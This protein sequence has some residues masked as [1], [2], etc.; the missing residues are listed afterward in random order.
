L[1]GW[2]RRSN[3]PTLRGQQRV[4]DGNGR[5]GVGMQKH[6]LERVLFIVGNRHCGKSTQLRSMF[7][8]VRLGTAGRIPIE[9]KLDDFHRLTNDRFLYLRLSSP[10][11]LNESPRG[12][13]AKTEDKI[14]AAH[15]ELGTRWNFASALQANASKKMP[16]AVET[17]STFVEHFHPERTRVAV[18]NP[19]R[20]G[21]F[22]AANG[23]LR[24][25][26]RLRHIPSVEVCRIDARDGKA[27]GL[28]LA[29]FFNF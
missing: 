18:L 15:L 19:D 16:D 3:T 7:R 26:H 29:D 6:H 22:L 14:R 21:N 4:L 28:L 20:K 10:H 5:M 12:F 8:D 9:R 13:L 1:T 2:R 23:T 17:C 27:N 25:A 11:E 24:D